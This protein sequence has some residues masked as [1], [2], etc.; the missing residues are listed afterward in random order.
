MAINPSGSG[1]RELIQLPQ[2]GMFGNVEAWA[3]MLIAQLQQKMLE[4][5][6]LM[7][8]VPPGSIMLLEGVAADIPAGWTICDGTDSAPDLTSF[9]PSGIIGMMKL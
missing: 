3:N 4:Q 9:L 5:N 1:E 7:N 2:L 6:V 8:Q